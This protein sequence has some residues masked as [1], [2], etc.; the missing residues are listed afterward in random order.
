MDKGLSFHEE[1]SPKSTSAFDCLFLACDEASAVLDICLFLKCHNDAWNTW[2]SRESRN[3]IWGVP[4]L[5]DALY[6][7]SEF[8]IHDH[9]NYLELDHV[10]P[11]VFFG[12]IK[13]ETAGSTLEIL[14]RMFL[15]NGWHKF[16][17]LYF[18]NFCYSSRENSRGH[19]LK[20]WLRASFQDW[21][22]LACWCFQRVD[23][24]NFSL[25]SVIASSGLTPLVLGLRVAWGEGWF[26]RPGAGRH[27][28]HLNKALHCWLEDMASAGL[29]LGKYGSYE[30]EIHQQTSPTVLQG[31]TWNRSAWHPDGMVHY[32]GGEP[33]PVF[34][35]FTFGPR[36]EDWELILDF[37]VE[38]YVGEFFEWAAC[39]ECTE[40][41]ICFECAV[42]SG[43]PVFV[44]PAIPGGW[45]EDNDSG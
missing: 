13:M 22:E 17:R 38:D 9:I 4:G 27:V 25:S 42:R 7:P 40:E 34:E 20:N 44:G 45:V 41:E 33:R 39:E 21:R 16:T 18:W 10:D 5:K 15:R 35:S 2:N 28:A 23:T 6:S 8:R 14:Q 1:R 31:T 43:G 37:V 26:R 11:K 24:E 30:W 19:P 3:L 29:D 36:P 32:E 12:I